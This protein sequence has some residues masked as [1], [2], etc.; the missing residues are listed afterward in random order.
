VASVETKEMFK[1]NAVSEVRNM[2]RTLTLSVG[3]SKCSDEEHGEDLL[4]DASNA[5]SECH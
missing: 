1:A 2:E 3:C 5:V 4:W